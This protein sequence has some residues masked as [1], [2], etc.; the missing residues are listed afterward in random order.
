VCSSDLAS[1]YLKILLDEIFGKNNFRNEI[2]WKRSSAHNDAKQG[3]KAFGNIS[4]VILYYSKSNAFK[5][6]QLYTAYTDNYINEFYKYIDENGR[7]YRL[8]NIA[9]PGGA[10]K[11][12]P[13]YEIMGVTRHWRYS[14]EKMQNLIKDGRVIQTKDGNV[15][16]YK[17]YLDEMPGVALQ[18]IWDDIKPVSS[19]SKEKTGYPTQKPLLLLHRIIKTSTNPGDIV[20][21]PFCGCA[22]TC[23]AA[24]QLGRK[25]IGM[26]IEKQAVNILVERLS[27]DAGL[28]KD[29]VNTVN[30]PQ[31]TDITIEIPSASVRERLYKEQNGLCN[32]CGIEFG[33]RNLEIDHIIPKSKGGGDYYENY[34]LLCSAC[35]RTKGDRPMEYLR[36]KIKTREMLIENKIIFGE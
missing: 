16:A 7:K 29:F 8:D 14:L 35:N 31:R 25:W 22:T 21:D 27:N 2:T 15:P 13:E 26:D 24:Q 11:G 34:Q 36:T 1:H 23:V 12:N 3:R 5:F 28:F 17:R 9:G 32:A 10:S 4:D 6:N 30:V 19:Q 33:I 20:L 18:N